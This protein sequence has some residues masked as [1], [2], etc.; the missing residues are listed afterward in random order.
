MAFAN[1]PNFLAGNAQIMVKIRI[2]RVDLKGFQKTFV[3]P[4]HVRP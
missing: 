4:V 1:C 2:R 3:L